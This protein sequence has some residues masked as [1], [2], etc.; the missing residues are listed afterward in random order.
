[1]VNGGWRACPEFTSG[2]ALHHFHHFLKKNET[3]A[4]PSVELSITLK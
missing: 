2:Q 4:D 1:M 3:E